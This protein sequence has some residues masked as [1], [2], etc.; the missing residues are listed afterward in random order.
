MVRPAKRAVLLGDWLAVVPAAVP[1]V[2]MLPARTPAT[3]A[4][5]A[6]LTGGLLI[7][8]VRAGPAESQTVASQAGRVAAHDGADAAR[9]GAT[10]WHPGRLTSWQYDLEWPVAVPTNV[11][12]VQ[13]YDIDYDGSEEGS[14]AQVTGVV[15]KIH[16]EGAHAICYVETGG[17]ED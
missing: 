8:E 17:W 12:A 2:T 1:A 14:E 4:P 16:A 15:G 6:R 11:G 10:W 9:A 3:A 5:R 13:V 7:G